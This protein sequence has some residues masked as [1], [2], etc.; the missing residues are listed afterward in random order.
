MIRRG[1]ILLHLI[2]PREGVTL[3][4]RI[5]VIEFICARKL[6]L[7]ARAQSNGFP[8]K[9]KRETFQGVQP[10]KNLIN[11]SN[12][13]ESDSFVLFRVRLENLQSYI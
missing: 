9:I 7:L 4:E 12:P 5:C 11:T 3:S 8:L 10:T 2:Y 6:S 1:L 13:V